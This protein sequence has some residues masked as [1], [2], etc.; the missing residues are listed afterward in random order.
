MNEPTDEQ[1]SEAAAPAAGAADA[2]VERRVRRSRRTKRTAAE[3]VAA[4]VAGARQAGTASAADAQDVP[5]AV[6]P[7]VAPP[8]APPPSGPVADA[9]A[10]RRRPGMVWG[11]IAALAVLVVAL[12][13]VTEATVSHSHATVVQ[14]TAPKVVV[15]TVPKPKTTTTKPATSTTTATTPSSTTTTAAR[16]VAAN[17]AP[18]PGPCSAGDVTVATV[19]DESAYAAGEAVH[20]TTK[21]T[22]RTACVFQP[23]NI[24]GFSCPTAITASQS[25]GAKVWPANNQAEQCSAPSPLTMYPGTVLTVAAVWNQQVYPS[26]GGSQQAAAGTYVA[27]GEWAWSGGAGKP[28]VVVKADSVPFTIA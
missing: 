11:A 9:P 4:A 27:S 10:P 25:G 23:T 15:P 5:T 2:P 1:P 18:A 8:A 26:G 14:Q 3:A 6:Q 12:A 21:V 13:I 7:A 20:V 22:D 28:P 19:T 17:A 16:P 24:P